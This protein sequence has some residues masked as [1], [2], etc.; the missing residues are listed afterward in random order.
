MT[1]D[2]ISRAWWRLRFEVR[3]SSLT[4]QDFENVVQAILEHRFPDEYKPVKAA[5]QIGDHKCDGLLSE[6]RRLIQCYGPEGWD[7]KKSTDKIDSDFAGAVEH[8]DDHFDTWVFAHNS[9]TGAPPYV[10]DSLDKISASED[11]NKTAEEW[12]FAKLREFAFELDDEQL[13]DLL[14]PA[15]TLADVL[16]VE[17]SDIAP[18]LKAVEDAPEAPLAE[19]APVPV[20]KLERN[21]FSDWAILLLRSGRRRSPA[22]GTYFENLKTRPLFRDDLG[23][24]FS[25]QYVSLQGD[26]LSPDETLGALLARIAGPTP[27]PK[28]QGAALTVI[29][30]FLDQCDIFEADLEEPLT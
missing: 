11:T 25:A 23:T 18:L 24:R 29:A 17:I 30:Y 9:R 19:I 27:L 12:G 21:D 13:T 3:F 7:K 16:D 5:G 4:G 8:W 22:V 2:H 26:G 15:I 20:D 14:G 10:H 1:S 6:Q 28:V